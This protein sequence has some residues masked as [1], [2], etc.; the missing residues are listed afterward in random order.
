[1]VRFN[2]EEDGIRIDEF[3]ADEKDADHAFR[4]VLVR[5]RELLASRELSAQPQK[6]R[7]REAPKIDGWEEL[8]RARTQK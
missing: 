2:Q 4:C 8:L 5:R 7:K 1:M 3:G 6:R